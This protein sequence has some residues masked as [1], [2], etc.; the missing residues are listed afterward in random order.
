MTKTEER[1][2]LIQHVIE[3]DNRIAALEKRIDVLEA[4]LSQAT[5]FAASER[6]EW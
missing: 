2:Q 4:A 6:I 1:N 3:R 5:Q